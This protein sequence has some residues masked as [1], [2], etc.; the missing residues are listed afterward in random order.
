MSAIQKQ[1]SQICIS[2]ESINLADNVNKE[3]NHSNVNRSQEVELSLN[4]KP[5]LP[6]LP[7]K[8]IRLKSS[9]IVNDLYLNADLDKVIHLNFQNSFH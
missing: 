2:S 7:Q 1:P 6:K 4:G 5:F 9:R 3:T 8:V